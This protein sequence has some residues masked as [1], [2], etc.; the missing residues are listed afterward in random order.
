MTTKMEN[1]I[2]LTAPNVPEMELVVSEVAS[3]I[4]ASSR[5]TNEQAEEI[6]MAVIEVCLNSFEHSKSTEKYIIVK[7][8]PQDDGLKITI[9]DK[10]I[11]FD[12]SIVTAP[13][14]RKIIS[15]E[16]KRHRGWGLKIVR[17]LMD[18]VKIDSNAEGTIITL[19]K[20]KNIVDKSQGGAL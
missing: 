4:A 14:I 1:E 19:F 13:D 3:S 7:F 2:V 6:K 9:Q 15:G 17:S 10:G 12:P 20:R 8:I 18:E 16:E 5:L 11:G